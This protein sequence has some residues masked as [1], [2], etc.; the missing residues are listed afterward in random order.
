[1][2]KKPS[3]TLRLWAPTL[4]LALMLFAAGTLTT[5]RTQAL[6]REATQQ[7]SAQLDRLQQA[8]SE[9]REIERLVETA[10]DEIAV[11]ALGG[12]SLVTP[13][14]DD[15][16]VIPCQTT[17]QLEGDDRNGIGQFHHRL[18]KPRVR[19]DKCYFQ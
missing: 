4:F 6:I 5:V 14:V 10:E 15:H 13:A 8:Q 18:G 1:M 11:A 3:I 12:L 2:L 7:Q 17:R 16:L 9:K 19:I